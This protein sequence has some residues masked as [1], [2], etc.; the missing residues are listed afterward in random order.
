MI[1][2]DHHTTAAAVAR[3]LG[4]D[5]FLAEVLPAQKAAEIAHLEAKGRTVAMAGDGI[6]DALCWPRL[7]SASR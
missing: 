4:L 5:D 6:N 1:T 3:R 7:M 2:G